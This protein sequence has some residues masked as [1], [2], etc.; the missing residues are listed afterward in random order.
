MKFILSRKKS[1]LRFLK[2]PIKKK[3]EKK[4]MNRNL[5]NVNKIIKKDF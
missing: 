1:L 3:T 5:R 4:K 2:D